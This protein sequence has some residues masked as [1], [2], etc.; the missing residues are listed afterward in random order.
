[1]LAK[2][3][4]ITIILTLTLFASIGTAQPLPSKNLEGQWTG[5]LD[6]GGQKLR[7]AI[8]ITKNA[9]KLTGTLDSLD[10]PGA[11]GIPISSAEQSGDEVKLELSGIGAHYRGKM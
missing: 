3:I 10:Q 5:T 7:L 1:M 6:A 2:K 4:A 11:N 8:T 9:E